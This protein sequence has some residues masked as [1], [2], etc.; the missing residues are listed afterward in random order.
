MASKKYAYYNK[1]NKIGLVEKSY[2]GSSGNL[3]VAHCTISG[4]TTSSDCEAAGGQWIPGSSGGLDNYGKYLSPTER[5]AD[6]LEIEYTYAPTYNLQST[7]TEGTDFHR[8]IGWGSDGTNLLLFTFGSTTVA[9]LSSLFA[10]DDWILIKGSGR[11]SGLHQ[12]KSTGG[13]KGVLTLKTKC[14][15]KP[16][17]II[18][19]GTFATNETFNGDD[20]AN[21]MD[22]EAFKDAQSHISK[23]Y[24]FIE[25]AAA[26]VSN[27][28]F[29]LS[30]DTTSGQMT[31]NNKITIDADGDYTSTAAAFSAQSSDSVNIYNA[32][33]EQISVYEGVEVMQDESF[34][35]DISHQQAQAIVYYL[36]AKMFEEMGDLERREFYLREFRRAVEKSSTDKR[37]GYYRIQGHGM[38]R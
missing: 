34:E 10:A 28:L 11:W 20:A 14:N 31:F 5:V 2:S 35:L 19:V 6:G 36:R 12:V 17:K 4:Y 15:L 25:D 13:T 23:P 37:K 38:I 8:F 3:A 29:S 7:G 27:G 30:T 22:I 9:N 1:G 24:V 33:Y 26:T 18:V 21:D 16:S 32:F